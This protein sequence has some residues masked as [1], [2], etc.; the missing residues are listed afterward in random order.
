MTTTHSFNLAGHVAVVLGGTSG[1]GRAL[2]RGLA[3][4]GADVVPSSRRQD[5]VEQA[6]AEVTARGR[7]TLA[8]SSDVLST[9]SLQQLCE[10]VIEEFGKVDILLNC[11]G[12]T[13]R[14][15][16]LQV[17]EE[18]WNVILGTNLSGTFR[19]CQV[20]GRAMLDRRA[21]SIINI[22]SLAS[23]LGL[24]EVAAYTASKSAVLGLTRALAVEWAPQGVRVNAISPGVFPTPL[25]EQLLTGTARGQEFLLR[26]PMRRFGMV[27]EL[28]GAAVYLA[29]D[30]SGFVTGTTI[31]VDGGFL[32]SGV[33]Q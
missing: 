16:S 1:I 29:S 33:N 18:E 12:Q 20:F 21:G 22:A 32:A 5:L 27:D 2:S 15:P 19:A 25:N 10:R 30:A 8:I 6:A 4:A 11:A 23:H 14:T 31:A 26:T 13:K 3:E 28:V 17:S 24:L 9:S 7:R